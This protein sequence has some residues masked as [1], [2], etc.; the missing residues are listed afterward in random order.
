[1][2]LNVA[3]RNGVT[4]ILIT[5]TDFAGQPAGEVVFICSQRDAPP[6]NPLGSTPQRARAHRPRLKSPV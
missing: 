3:P 4:L 6:R 5:D 1:M 2:S